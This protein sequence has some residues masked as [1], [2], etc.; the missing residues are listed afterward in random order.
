MCRRYLSSLAATVSV[1]LCFIGCS[2]EKPPPP[3]KIISNTAQLNAPQYR[4]GLPEGAAAMT[5]GEKHFPSAELLYFNSLS[6]AYTAVSAGKIDAFIFDRHSLE[7]VQTTR[8]DLAVLD[9]KIADEHIVIGAPNS[10]RNLMNEVNRFIAQYRQ[11]GTYTDMVDRW[12]KGKDMSLPDIA[13]PTNPTRT[14]R[15]GTEGLNEPMNY[16][17]DNGQ[18]TGFDIEF[19]R[20]LALFLKAR[21]E[22]SAMTFPALIPAAES[23]KIDLLIASLNYTPERS[24]IMLFSDT[25]V[26]SE[27]AAIVRKDRLPKKRSPLDRFQGQKIASLA[28]TV[29]DLHIDRKIAGVQHQYFQD[30]SSMITALQTGKV[31]AVGVDEPIGRLAVSRFPE[32]S[33]VPVP[34]CIDEYGFA[35]AKGSPLTV[36][37]SGVVRKLRADGTLKAMAEY[38][39]NAQDTNKAMPKFTHRPDFDGSAGVL[40]F[41]HDNVNEPMSYVGPDGI[42]LGFDVELAAHIAYEL[43]MVFQPTPCGFGSLLESLMAGKADMVGGAMS[44]TPERQKNVDFIEGYYTGGIYL[45]ERADHAAVNTSNN[46]AATAF[47]GKQ[48]AIMTGSS[49][50]KIQKDELPNAIPQYFNAVADMFIALDQGKLDGILVDEPSAKVFCAKNSKL[51]IWDEPIVSCSYA[52]ALSHQKT[53]LCSAINQ[54]LAELRQNGGLDRLNSKWLGANEK[55]KIVDDFPATGPKGTLRIV[56]DPVLEPFSYIKDGRPVGYDM[57]IIVRLAQ[58][59]EMGIEVMTVDFPALIPAVVSGKADIGIGGI[60]VTDERKKNVLFTDSYYEGG[61]V[62]LTTNATINADNDNA[63]WLT[64][65]AQKLRKS[66]RGTFVTENRWQLVLRGLG[67]TVVISLCSILL[68]TLMGFAVCWLRRS[69]RP[70]LASPAKLYIRAVQGTPILVILMIIYYVIFGSVNVNAIA[71]AI[72]AFAVNFSAYCS[73]MFRTGIDAVDRG[74]LEAADAIGFSRWQSFRLIVVPQAARHVLP[75]YRGEAIANIK[76]TSIVGYIAIQDL[77]KVSDII[78]SRTYEAFFPLIATALLYFLLAYAVAALL[79][80]LER[81]LQPQARR[82]ALTQME[83][84]S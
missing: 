27:I 40:R 58:K 1:I 79:A 38:W 18:L 21:L 9:E 36:K 19:V 20:R 52:M 23:G 6:D 14:L 32:L 44:I 60:T 34:I 66:F 2:G 5:A 17:G 65:R 74:Q 67:V 30:M 63:G 24:K 25:Y 48:I 68:G 80:F 55:E 12:L 41:H 76:M 73:E 49:Y 46:T 62:V 28:G 70:L 31:A 51:A 82:R 7:Y 84:Q 8:D 71:V 3:V 75:V 53:D 69:P 29:F 15:V 39:F 43:N 42:S 22:V 11:D 83:A 33:L 61:V 10:N 77:T 64:R 35:I 57:D 4:I 50:D 45:L 16:Y 81:R 26:D 78:R 56:M 72:F 13:E 59:L 54:L 47:A 37:A